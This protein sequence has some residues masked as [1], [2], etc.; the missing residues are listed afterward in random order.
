M[1]SEALKPADVWWWVFPTVTALSGFAGGIFGSFFSK[2][3]EIGAIQSQI[4]TVVQQNE[5][6]VKSSEEIRSDISQRDWSKQRRWDM[7]R[8]IG[9]EIM[10]LFG[11]TL[12]TVG[13][14]HDLAIH[15]EAI[16]DKKMKVTKER[17]EEVRGAFENAQGEMLEHV[18]SYWQLGEVS[19]LVF[20]PAVQSLLGEV[21]DGYRDMLNAIW[22]YE[23]TSGENYA[24]R[25][26]AIV[27][28]EAALAT[29]IRNE[30][31][32]GST[33]ELT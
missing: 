33:S 32:F 20:S 14:F 9:I 8:D 17:E 18:A 21:R 12:R 4:N 24:P 7:Q 22:A 26:Q 11:A 23:M 25:M 6:L 15:Y 1:L 3:G 13:K 19:R 30:L 28:K 29:A 16:V 10:R 2:R 5:R 31:G 27:A